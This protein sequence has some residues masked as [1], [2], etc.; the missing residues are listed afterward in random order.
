MG[1]RQRKIAPKV[2]ITTEAGLASLEHYRRT[3]TG[4]DTEVVS[5]EREYRVYPR[6]IDML[7][8][9]T[10]MIESRLGT[11]GYP[12]SVARIVKPNDP[13]KYDRNS[14]TPEQRLLYKFWQDDRAVKMLSLLSARDGSTS[15]GMNFRY[16]IMPGMAGYEELEGFKTLCDIKR[17][18]AKGR[19]KVSTA[20]LCRAVGWR[21]RD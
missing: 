18:W 6:E 5:S 7:P 12:H 21:G 19:V 16:I 13:L 2:M 10:F 3:P 20:L 9:D 15:G 14:L 17:A 1:I 8:L 11:G 4:R